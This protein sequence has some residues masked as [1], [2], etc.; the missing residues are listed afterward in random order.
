MKNIL[1]SFFLCLFIATSSLAFSNPVVPPGERIDSR[2]K[3]AFSSSDGGISSTGISSFILP[4]NIA[5]DITDEGGGVFHYKYTFPFLSSLWTGFFIESTSGLGAASLS[6]IEINTFFPVVGNSA[7]DTT[8]GGVDGILF[9]KT[10]IVDLLISSVSFRVNA[11]P[12]YG[13]FRNGSLDS[14]SIVSP[15]VENEGFENIIIA[16]KGN[17]AAI[18]GMKTPDLATYLTLSTFLAFTVLTLRKK[19]DH[20][21]IK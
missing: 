20:K 14:D 9:S 4:Y 18:I 10:I 16:P 19:Y 21:P 5:W 3:S 11:I 7:V 17:F 1:V 12:E 2:S 6:D 15:Y 8:I 13:D